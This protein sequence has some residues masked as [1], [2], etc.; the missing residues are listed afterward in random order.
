MAELLAFYDYPAEHWVHL[1]TTNPIW[2]DFRDG[3]APD[4]GHQGPGLAGG[5]PGDGVQA[6]RV[7]LRP[8]A[9]R[10]RASS[11]RLG[12]RRGH[13][14]QRQARRTAQRGDANQSSLNDLDP[15]VLTIALGSG[16]P[17]RTQMVPCQGA[18]GLNIPPLKRRG[19]M[20]PPDG[21]AWQPSTGSF[22]N[23]S[24]R[25]RKQPGLNF[26]HRHG[27]GPRRQPVR[28]GQR[29]RCTTRCTPSGEDRHGR[30]SS[31]PINSRLPDAAV[32]RSS[33][34]RACPWVS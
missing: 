19:S 20:A 34:S 25:L 17:V 27:S 9:L 8:L 13:V 16:G 32:H 2:V 10:E 12:P 30:R 24:R 33:S 14:H 23:M 21:C 4:Q 5:G 6:D 22:R 7:S 15:Q 31:R 18:G 29:L 1:R 3:Q 26:P 28:L 11:R